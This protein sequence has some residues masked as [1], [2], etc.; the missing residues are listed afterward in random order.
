MKPKLRLLPFLFGLLALVFFLI[1]LDLRTMLILFILVLAGSL[2]LLYKLF[3]NIPLG[4]E[5]VT[6]VTVLAGMGISAKAG[7]FV[8]LI[9]PLLGLSFALKT[10]KN[11]GDTLLNMLFMGLVGFLSSFIPNGS[12]AL[13]GFF[14]TLLFD[15]L[16]L[17]T[18]Y[19]ISPNLGKYAIYIGG[20]WLFN[21]ALFRALGPLGLSL[22]RP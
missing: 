12:I 14:L 17:P 19:F 16:Y 4:F 15:G 5:L 6:L 1:I 7:I 13:G 10:F 3:I 20:H 2:S 18:R 11:P 8:G 21:Y 9:T 22:I